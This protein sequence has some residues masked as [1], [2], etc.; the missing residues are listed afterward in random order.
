MTSV[1]RLW[2]GHRPEGGHVGD[3]VHDYVDD[4]LDAD[5]SFRLDRHLLV[6]EMC[7]HEVEQ[8]RLLIEQLRGFRPD[9][10]RHQSL[11][12]GLLGL[13]EQA[14]PPPRPA[15][16]PSLVTGD[17]PPQY[18]SARNSVTAAL[19]AVVGCAGVALV[20]STTPARTTPPTRPNNPAQVQVRQ[21]SS[22]AGVSSDAV[23][24]AEQDADGASEAPGDRGRSALTVSRLP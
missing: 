18:Q 7:R 4:A 2:R 3:L 14:P 10:A 8:E 16:G 17:A 5:L 21:A 22:P 6:C 15:C 9:P 11:V 20:V 12:D 24:R 23:L 13:A 19:V 1:P